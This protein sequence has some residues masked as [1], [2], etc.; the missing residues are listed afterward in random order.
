MTVRSGPPR[1]L[2][3]M[4][5]AVLAFA[6]VTCSTVAPEVGTPTVVTTGADGLRPVPDPLD[7]PDAEEREPGSE[8]SRPEPSGSG[9][10]GEPDD[11][12]SPAPVG[13]AAADAEPA[14]ARERARPDEAEARTEEESDPGKGPESPRPAKGSD[15]ENAPDD[16]APVAADAPRL[17]DL[18]VPSGQPTRV[19]VPRIG[20]DNPLVPVGLHA[21]K[22]L[23]VPEQAHVA[24]WYTGRP[25][26]GETGPAIVA[27]HNRWGGKSGVFERLHAL[28]AGDVI[29]VHHDD[30]SVVRF[31]VDRL[32][33][34]PKAAFPTDRVYGPTDR[35]EI[36]VIT[37]GGHFDRSRGSHVDNVIAFGVRTG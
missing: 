28:S 30:G 11:G 15:A 36:R 10:P 2:V 26:P 5:L 6:L 1:L 34:H 9:E 18:P 7:A 32:E 17:Q 19:V 27:G 33:Q 8:P 24:G 21:D 13:D 37:C 35:A 25:R 23:V 3:G 20:V 16:T 29:E 31:E 14:D 12:P 4:L 22:S